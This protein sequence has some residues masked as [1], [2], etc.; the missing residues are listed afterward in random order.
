MCP[1]CYSFFQ[2]LAF[3]T[4]SFWCFRFET[5]RLAKLFNA[6]YET[7]LLIYTKFQSFWYCVPI[8]EIHSCRIWPT[9]HYIELKIIRS[10]NC[11]LVHMKCIQ[12]QRWLHKILKKHLNLK[13]SQNKALIAFVILIGNHRIFPTICKSC[14]VKSFG[15]QPNSI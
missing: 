2:Y 9:I 8:F 3:N 14:N 6:N 11:L 12:F 5:I 1:I 13:L 10:C 7:I 4:T 15:M